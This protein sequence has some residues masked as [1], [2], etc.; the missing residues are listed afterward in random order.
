MNYDIR[1]VSKEELKPGT[2]I[3][4]EMK[5]LSKLESKAKKQCYLPEDPDDHFML[6][7]FDNE[8]KLIGYVF[9]SM[10]DTYGHEG[11]Y[12]EAL[13]VS[14]GYQKNGVGCKLLAELEDVASERGGKRIELIFDLAKPNLANSASSV[15]DRG[16]VPFPVNTACFQNAEN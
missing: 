7:A 10:I 4:E 15:K 1:E 8:K 11:V 13:T 14:K 12:A 2:P 9:G 16:G 3:Y 6:G 5:E